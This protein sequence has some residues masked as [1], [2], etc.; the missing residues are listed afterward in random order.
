MTC[1]PMNLRRYAAGWPQSSASFRHFGAHEPSSPSTP[2]SPTTTSSSSIW[3]R[4]R[5]RPKVWGVVVVRAVGVKGCFGVGSASVVDFANNKIRPF[6]VH[7][8]VDRK[9]K[10]IYPEKITLHHIPYH[11]P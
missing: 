9:M 6:S 3:P 2:S 5:R 10:R 1:A 11:I 8:V 4:R 7:K